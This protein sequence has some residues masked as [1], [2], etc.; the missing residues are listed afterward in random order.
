MTQLTIPDMMVLLVTLCLPL[1][2][3]VVLCIVNRHNTTVSQFLMGDRHLSVFPV[4]VSLS[5]S[6]ISVN[7]VLNMSQEISLSSTIFPITM[8]LSSTLAMATVPNLFMSVYY[9]M[10]LTSTYEYLE[11][12]FNS[13]LVRRLG[14]LTF[15]VASQLYLGVILLTVSDHLSVITGVP[16]WPYLVCGGLIFLLVIACGGLIAVVW[17]DVWQAGVVLSCLT[18]V[19]VCGW[20][21]DPLWVVSSMG[22]ERIAWDGAG[23]SSDTQDMHNT[24]A[25]WSGQFILWASVYGCHQT[26]VQRYC[27]TKSAVHARWSLGVSCLITW[28]LSIGAM[29]VV[30]VITNKFDQRGEDST[31]I[32]NEQAVLLFIS[33]VFINKHKPKKSIP[34]CRSYPPSLACLVSIY[35]L[36]LLLLYQHFLL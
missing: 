35:L 6:F 26:T 21:D 32:K 19:I 2:M 4:A 3:T 29:L 16:A 27:S 15:I 25:M 9:K 14:S 17:T 7:T 10:H 30:M 5:V 22:R 13:P 23:W 20:G 11:L 24:L 33:K 8:L 12:R 36:L 1:V 28:I 31:Q 18:S 34:I